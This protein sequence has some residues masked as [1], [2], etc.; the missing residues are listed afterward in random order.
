[1]RGCL[2]FILIYCIECNDSIEKN[3]PLNKVYVRRYVDSLYVVLE[4]IEMLRVQ[5]D[6]KFS[7]PAFEDC[8]H[9]TSWKYGER[10]YDTILE[11]CNILLFHQF[12][13]INCD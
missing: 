2:L 9:A 11:V 12:Y 13:F 3:Y 7:E 8:L 1:M 5:D 4:A 10:L 6:I